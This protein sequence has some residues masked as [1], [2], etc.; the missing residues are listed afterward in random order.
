MNSETKTRILDAAEKLFA[1]NGY[2]ATSLRAITAAAGVNLAAVNYHFGTKEGLIHAVFAR[3]VGPINAQRL[4]ALGDLERKAGRRPL[5][6]DAIVRSL[7]GP[8]LRAVQNPEGSAAFRTLLGRAYSE[9]VLWITFAREFEEV[10]GRFTAALARALPHLPRTEIFW[11]LHFSIGATAHTLAAA[12]MLQRMS[13]G[14]C[15]H[16]GVEAEIDRLVAFIVPGLKA[17]PPPAG[18]RS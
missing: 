2:S 3:K 6:L 11:R 7:V 18:T 1:E 5:P 13:G 16:A 12:P 17:P 9:P 10:V 8:M 4:A 14:L 15:G